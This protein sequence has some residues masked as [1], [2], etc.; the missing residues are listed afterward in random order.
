MYHLLGLFIS[1]WSMYHLSVLI[2][3]LDLDLFTYQINNNKGLQKN[4]PIGNL[5]NTRIIAK[6]GVYY[7]CV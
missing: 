2:L 6:V 5:H 1:Y 3:Y 4:Y 7:I